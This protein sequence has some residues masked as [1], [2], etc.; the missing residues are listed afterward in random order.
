[1]DDIAPVI[2]HLDHLYDGTAKLADL[3][4]YQSAAVEAVE[5]A[6]SGNVVIL[7]GAAPI[8]LY[9]SIAHA[10]HGIARRLVY[11]SPVTGPVVIF[12]HNPF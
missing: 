8:W 11:E 10:L 9:L 4:Q 6:G 2:V 12:D 7:T 3:H 1:M 5:A